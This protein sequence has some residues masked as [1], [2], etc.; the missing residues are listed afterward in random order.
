MKTSVD[1]AGRLEGWT[2][3]SLELE[4]MAGEDS[5]LAPEYEQII[6]WNRKKDE[7]GESE[8][9]SAKRKRGEGGKNRKQK[10]PR[11]GY[12]DK[13]VSPHKKVIFAIL[14]FIVYS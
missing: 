14:T 8:N 3:E 5:C 12:P 6:N 2:C 11:Y 10:R 4:A 13:P 1:N 9:N 7:F